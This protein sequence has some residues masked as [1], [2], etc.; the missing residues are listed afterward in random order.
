[1]KKNGKQ[2]KQVEEVGNSAK[3]LKGEET[4]HQARTST[5]G[6]ESIK[7][8]REKVQVHKS[9]GLFGDV[10]SGYSLID[11]TRKEKSDTRIF[12]HMGGI[13]TKRLGKDKKKRGNKRKFRRRRVIR[14]QNIVGGA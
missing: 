13:A 10:H 14:V 8:E 12:Y 4:Y 11:R 1:M 5:P 2:K 6:R 3:E 7:T 9:T